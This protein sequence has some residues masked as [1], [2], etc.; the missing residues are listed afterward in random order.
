MMVMLS[1]CTKELNRYVSIFSEV[2]FIDCTAGEFVH[3]VLQCL[4][5]RTEFVPFI[6]YIYSQAPSVKQNNC[7]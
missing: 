6:L 7:L 4:N 1:I 3:S 5:K 2:W